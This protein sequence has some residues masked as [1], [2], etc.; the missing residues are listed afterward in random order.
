MEHSLSSDLNSDV[1]WA[2][3]A[4]WVCANSSHY[5][6]CVSQCPRSPDGGLRIQHRRAWP[7]G[8]VSWPRDSAGTPPATGSTH[9]QVPVTSGQGSLQFWDVFLSHGPDHASWSRTVFSVTSVTPLTRNIQ[10]CSVTVRSS[11]QEEE[12]SGRLRG[13]GMRTGRQVESSKREARLLQI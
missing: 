3:A 2:S 9:P 6:P 7:Q 5:D 13:P 10:A 11:E 4:C 12:G 8:G 1:H